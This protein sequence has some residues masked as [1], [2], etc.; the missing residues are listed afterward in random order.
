MKV[1]YITL[2][3]VSLHKG[4][5]IHIKEIVAGLRQA[6]HEVGLAA[7]SFGPIH[8]TESSHNVCPTFERGAGTLISYFVSGFLLLFRLFKIIDRYD[9]VYARDYHATVLAYLP[10]LLFQKKLIFEINGLANEEQRLKKDSLPNRAAVF[11][12]RHAEKEATKAADRIISVT[13][14]IAG[15]LCRELRCQQSKIEIVGNGVNT[16]K[17]HPIRDEVLLSGYRGRIGIKPGE[18]VLVFVGNLARWQG[19][20]T[21]IDCSVDLLAR[22]NTLKFLIVGDGPLR[23]KLLEKTRKARVENAV[24]FTGM[25]DYAEVPFYINLADIGVAP[26]ISNR[27]TKTGV[28]P[29]KIFE[30]MACGKPVVASRIEGLEF[31]EHEG[32]GRLVTPGAVRDFAEALNDLLQDDSKRAEMGE[33]ASRIAVEKFSWTSKV[34][35]I[36]GILQ[37]MA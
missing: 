5:V 19:I 13:P 36:Q 23:A 31:I 29:L 26:F 7:R 10:C 35:K 33:K 1:L 17:F 24:I 6:G 15:Y 32:V 14:Q 25:V 20:E 28:S 21:L 22:K 9:L 4:S 8:D 3:N 30:Y 11:L 12:I 34:E 16:A 37:K 18:R 2:E 27:N